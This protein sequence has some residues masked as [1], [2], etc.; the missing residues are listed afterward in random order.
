MIDNVGSLFLRHF[1]SF[2]SCTTLNIFRNAVCLRFGFVSCHLL[3]KR[4]CIDSW[5]VNN[6]YCIAITPVEPNLHPVD[7]A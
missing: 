1:L 2:C 6:K 7:Y 3:R 5:N 4:V